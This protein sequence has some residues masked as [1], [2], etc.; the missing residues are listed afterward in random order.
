MHDDFWLYLAIA[1]GTLIG[2]YL[3]I[4]V[5]AMMGHMMKRPIPKT[6]INQKVLEIRKAK[7]NLK[8]IE[9]QLARLQPTKNPR[10][11][12]RGQVGE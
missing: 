6:W 7:A 11:E 5:V 8:R 9:R 3:V 12:V 10:T 2:C 1:A 4:V